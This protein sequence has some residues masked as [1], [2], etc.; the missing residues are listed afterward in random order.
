MSEAAEG[1]QKKK[2]QKTKIKEETVRAVTAKEPTIEKFT[3]RETAPKDT[4]VRRNNAGESNQQ[5]FY[6]QPKTAS[7]NS[8][9]LHRIEKYNQHLK[10][11]D[12]GRKYIL[13][14]AGK[15]LKTPPRQILQDRKSTRLNSSHIH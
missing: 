4:A 1:K 5:D 11:Q 13:S 8:V 9:L 6:Y 12:Y 10:Y 14:P 15:V 2:G 3:A 7:S